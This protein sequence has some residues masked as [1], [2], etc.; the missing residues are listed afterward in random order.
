MERDEYREPRAARRDFVTPARDYWKVM[1]IVPAPS[2]R[3]N[4]LPPIAQ[5]GLIAN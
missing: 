3:A 5:T 4:P 1:N 2:Y